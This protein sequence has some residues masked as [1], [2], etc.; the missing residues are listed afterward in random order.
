VFFADELQLEQLRDVACR[1]HR[2]RRHVG[3]DAAQGARFVR[4]E[5]SPDPPVHEPLL[6]K[7]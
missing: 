4:T 1:Q 7:S 5:C 6:Q 2:A 3:G